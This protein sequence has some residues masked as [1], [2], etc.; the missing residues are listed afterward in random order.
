[1]RCKLQGIWLRKI[2]PVREISRADSETRLAAIGG[3]S[4][5]VDMNQGGTDEECQLRAPN[6]RPLS[7]T[8]DPAR[9]RLANFGDRKDWKVRRRLLWP[10]IMLLIILRCSMMLNGHP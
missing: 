10:R 6:R 3:F 1:M 9:T 2:R 5:S 4:I 7:Q 8:F